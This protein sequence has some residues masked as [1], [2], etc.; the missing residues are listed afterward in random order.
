MLMSPA[1]AGADT[2]PVDYDPGVIAAC[3]AAKS[4]AARRD[5]IGIGAQYCMARGAGSSNAGIGFCFGAERDDW[6]R[7]LNSAYLILLDQARQ[8]DAE[9]A[10]IGSAAPP[11]GPALQAMQRAWVAYRDASCQYE[12]TTWGGGSGAGPG[13]AHCEMTLTGAQALRLMARADDI[14]GE[15]Q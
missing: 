8:T 13:V 10:R 11:E 14:E 5:C 4:G 2:L 1:M 15:T 9:M 7:R 6:D 3:L 12:M